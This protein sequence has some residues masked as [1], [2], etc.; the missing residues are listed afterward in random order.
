MGAII[1]EPL[2]IPTIEY[3]LPNIE[4]LLA[5]ILLFKSVVIIAS[6]ISN[7]DFQ[8]KYLGY[9]E[10]N[11]NISKAIQAREPIIAYEPRG[12]TTQQIQKIMQQFYVEHQD[13]EQGNFLVNF[14]RWNK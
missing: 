6:E 8:L 5:E 7:L 2:A 13:K 3:F 9:I 10:E 11:S 4:K 12:K 14:F 1:P